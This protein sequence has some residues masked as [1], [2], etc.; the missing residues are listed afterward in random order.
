MLPEDLI[1]STNPKIPEK[2]SRGI[3]CIPE[4]Y[5]LKRE[6]DILEFDTF[7]AFTSRPGAAVDFKVRHSSSV[8]ASL[9]IASVCPLSA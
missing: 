9:P 5:R 4:S 7:T 2:I 8:D 3:N 6:D 1:S